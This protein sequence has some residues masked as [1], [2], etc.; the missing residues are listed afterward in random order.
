M[1]FGI[2]PDFWRILIIPSF[3]WIFKQFL[4]LKKDNADS[5]FLDLC[6]QFIDVIAHTK[7]KNLQFCFGF[8][9]GIHIVVIL[10]CGADICYCSVFSLVRLFNH[11]YFLYLG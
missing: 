4:L 6:M 8:P 10:C 3:L 9:V 11:K 5:F 2:L 1:F 7:Q